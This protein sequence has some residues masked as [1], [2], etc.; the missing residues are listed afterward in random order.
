MATVWIVMVD[1]AFV[2][3]GR[4]VEKVFASE[5]DARAYAATDP[6]CEVEAHEVESHA[7]TASRID[8]DNVAP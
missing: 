6:G 4:T 7:A 5:A 3:R 2:D 1:R 8:P